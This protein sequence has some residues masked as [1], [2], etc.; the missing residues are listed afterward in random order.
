MNAVHITFYFFNIFFN[1][2]LRST[3]R[4][5]MVSLSSAFVFSP[6]DGGSMF[7]QKLVCTYKSTRRYNPEDEHR[8]VWYP[9]LTSLSEPRPLPVSCSLIWA[10]LPSFSLHNS[11]LPLLIS[12]LV[13]PNTDLTSAPCSQNTS[14]TSHTHTKQR[15]KLQPCRQS[16][17]F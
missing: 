4:S 5:S 17:R 15:V 3:S 6:K 10:K 13:G 8:Q 12:S 2:T 1:I 14:L 9:L 11:P 16:L 7:L